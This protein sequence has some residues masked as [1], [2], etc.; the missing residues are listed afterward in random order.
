MSLDPAPFV[1][2]F[3]T[4]LPARG[5]HAELSLSPRT[6]PPVWIDDGALF[7]SVVLVVFESVGSTSPRD[8][9]EQEVCVGRIDADDLPRW[10][11]CLEANLRALPAL[12]DARGEDVELIMPLDVVGFPEALR[13]AELRDLEDFVRAFADPLYVGAWLRAREDGEWEEQLAG[14]GLAGHG[15]QVRALAQ[16]SI[17]LRAYALE[18][19]DDDE[20]P[21]GTTRI[22]G[23]PDLPSSM[24]WPAIGQEPLVFVAQLDL[25]SL[26]T[27]RAA[28][29]LPRDGVLSFFYD[30]LA[31]GNRA[32]GVRVFHFADAK[33]LA[34]RPL[35]ERVERVRQHE[36][37]LVSERMYPPIE[38][39]FYEALL[40]DATQRAFRGALKAAESGAAGRVIDP[41]ATV[42]TAMQYRN[43]ADPERPM[44]RV[45]GYAASI[46]G[47]PYLDLETTVVRGGY[48][49]WDEASDE[50]M[51]LRRS[52]RRWRLLLQIDASGDGELLLNQDG[53]F[54]Y[55]WIT[56]DA[57]RAHDWSAVRGSLQC[58]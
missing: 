30:P 42:A 21:P 49:G 34:R 10:T 58:H 55:F 35:P 23:S 3:V 57:L 11:A 44:H 16:P 45:L 39:P 25:A 37:E 43:D 28:A 46:Q 7:A 41:L 40:P 54:F 9:K 6:N 26:A 51:A 38:S 47:D 29:D 27:Q 36:V 32:E 50:A 48:D 5:A 22:G 4:H 33:T 8:I 12:L 19:G 31:A 1:Q 13:D 52:A 56:G 15:A 17:R 14:S 24:A 2:A 53:G 20:A 18:E